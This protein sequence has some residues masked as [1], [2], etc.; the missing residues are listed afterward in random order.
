VVVVL[1]VVALVAIGVA[2]GGSRTDHND[3]SSRSR[4]QAGTLAL[5]DWLRDGLGLGDQ[6]TRVSGDFRLDG[7]DLLVVEEPTSAFTDAD[8]DAVDRFVRGG[9]EVLLAAD[10]SAAA[11]AQGLFD[12][13]HA[14]PE[15]R[16]ALTETA[17]PAQ[18]IDPGDRI[19]T[20][21]IAAGAIVF[22]DRPEV[23]PLLSV[24]AGTVMI[25]A[26]AGQG[27]VYVLGS[28]YPLS[29]VGLRPDGGTPSD[30]GALVL[31]LLE[32]ARGGHVGFDEVHHG[33]G[34]GQVGA[35]AVFD[36]PVG[37]AAGLAAVIVLL[38]LG[39]SGRRLGRPV[40]AGDASRVPSAG[41]F[42]TALAQLYERSR[43]R[44][45][46]AGRYGDELKARVSAATGID[47]RLEDET[48]V[49][50]LGAFGADRAA[51]VAQA[52]RRARALATGRPDDASLLQLARQV[53]EV[54]QTWTAGG[55]A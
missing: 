52:L 8:V 13:F 48:F 50:A 40:P 10:A 47:R 37:I 6:V 21:P 14:Q 25:G 54:E 20:V 29:N 30:A 3:P 45:P 42:I 5:Y 18:P 33:E 9:G 38:F 27:R 19:D 55:V 23:T 16:D 44:G 39:L 4:G 12:R 51:E 34:A 49:A 36:G 24:S 41:E 35:A 17:K 26:P 11:G 46:V 7:L 2:A 28:P 15:S 22:A 32:R 53:D 1:G 43:L 31:A